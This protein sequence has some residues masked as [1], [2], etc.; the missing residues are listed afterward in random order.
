[1]T[2]QERLRYTGSGNGC[3][4]SNKRLPYPRLRRPVGYSPVPAPETSTAS[5]LYIP[6]NTPVTGQVTH[7][8]AVNKHNTEGGV[9]SF[10]YEIIVNDC[11]IPNSQRRQQEQHEG[12]LRKYPP[13][14]SSTG[15]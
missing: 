8:V 13:R 9:Y 3:H 1:M 15:T 5:M 10:A 14:M 2:V 6:T 11:W 7:A 4:F 12:G